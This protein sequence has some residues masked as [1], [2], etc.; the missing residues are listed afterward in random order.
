[1]RYYEIVWAIFDEAKT[2]KPKTPLV[3]TQSRNQRPSYSTASAAVD[4]FRPPGG[5]LIDADA[6]DL[7]DQASSGAMTAKIEL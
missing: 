5:G 6:E 4:I 2:R 3:P 1:M 7:V